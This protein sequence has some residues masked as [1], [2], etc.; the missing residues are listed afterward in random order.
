MGVDGTPFHYSVA[1]PVLEKVVLK[2][3]L[4]TTRHDEGLKQAAIGLSQVAVES[5]CAISRRSFQES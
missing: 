4:C 1:E 2:E 5:P 3:Y